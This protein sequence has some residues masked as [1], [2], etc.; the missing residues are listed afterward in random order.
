MATGPPPFEYFPPTPA[1][2]TFPFWPPLPVHEI[3][4]NRNLSMCPYGGLPDGA[5]WSK[6]PLLNAAA[7]S[8]YRGT[9]KM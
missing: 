7:A 4:S 6:K 2:R 3:I 5:T 8:F 1:T 9:T